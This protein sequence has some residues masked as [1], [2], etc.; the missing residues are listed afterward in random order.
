MNKESF[1]IVLGSILSIICLVVIVLFAIKIEVH[2]EVEVLGYNQT[3]TIFA[4][5]KNTY[6]VDG[7]YPDGT[8]LLTVDGENVLDVW[9]AVYSEVE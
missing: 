6:L 5:D 1:G 2:T 3:Q 7:H 9:Q 4:T 8:Y